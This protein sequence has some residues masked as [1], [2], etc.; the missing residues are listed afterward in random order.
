MG[1]LDIDLKGGLNESLNRITSPFTRKTVSTA[2][3]KAALERNDFPDGFEMLEY[4]EGKPLTREKVVLLA[5]Q[6]PQIPFEFGGTQRIVKDYYPGQSEPTVQVLGAREGDITIRGRL[7][8][9]KF[10][11]ESPQG[12]DVASL[13]DSITQVAEGALQSAG[14]I[15]GGAFGSAEKAKRIDESKRRIPQEKQQLIEAMR[16]RGN[17]VRITMGDFQR[18]GFIENAI[19][20]MK[21]LADI[22]YEITFSIIG[23]NPPSDCKILGRARTVPIDI[24]KELIAAS[25]AFLADFSSVPDD[26][27]RTLAE[28]INSLIGDVAATVSLVTS[29]VDNTLT[30][31]DAVK[32][33]VTRAIGLIKNA[34][35]TISSTQRQLGAYDAFLEATFGISTGAA[36]AYKNALF[37]QQLSSSLR[38]QALILANLTAALDNLSKTEPL[39]RHRIKS[40]D[41]LQE[42][43][44]K[45]YNDHT[46]WELIYDHNKLQ[47]VNLDDDVGAILEIPRVS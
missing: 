43:A 14:N 30:E 16:I 42:I 28:Q 10:G 5:D 2:D 20:R 26:V 37:A 31:V 17:L 41:T 19:F 8:A 9:K 3:M 39:G 32:N 21:T 33:T 13:G 24:N 1:L 35:A 27:P 29:F 45:F 25:D 4:E 7:K 34:R 22:D 18:F 38:G 47:D 6:M 15:V 44:Q 12:F 36:A 40:G 46:Q 23:F 11:K